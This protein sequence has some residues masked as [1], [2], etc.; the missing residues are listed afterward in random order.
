[1]LS[2]LHELV[3]EKMKNDSLRQNEVR[4]TR[5]EV[6]EKAGLSD[7]QVRVHLE[8]LVELEYVFSHC[9]KN[10]SR[11][12]YELV[13][14]GEMQNNKPQL[15][16]LIDINQLINGG[17]IQSPVAE[18][19][20]PVHGL[21][22]DSGQ[23]EASLYTHKNDLQANSDMGLSKSENQNPEKALIGLKNNALSNLNHNHS[24]TNPL[25]AGV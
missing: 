12:V 17:T 19:Q 13:F 7:K 2:Q 5:R 3:I 8:R 11:Y 16:G 6:R 21:G 18:N 1:L 10:G 9:G 24:H 25:A 20:N 15:T 4:F 23:R 22:P 14:D